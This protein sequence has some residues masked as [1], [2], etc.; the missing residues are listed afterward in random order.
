MT[1]SELTRRVAAELRE[2]DVRK[3]VILPRYTLH[4]SDDE[5]NR[6]DF[7][8]KKTDK[9]VLFTKDD[10]KGVLDACMEIIKEA[11]RAGEGIAVPGFGKLELKYRKPRRA[12]NPLTG[13]LIDVAG[14]YV[15]KVTFGSE[16][17]LSARIYELSLGSRIKDETAVA[18]DDFADDEDGEPDGD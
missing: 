7:F 9:S 2:R 4:V 17:R 12:A 5:G 15:P 1:Y 6:K 13:E 3:P 16:M 8:I 14:R 18:P 10:V 11:V